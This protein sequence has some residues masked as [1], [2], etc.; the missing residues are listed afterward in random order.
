MTVRDHAGV[1]VTV[2]TGFLG[3]GKTTLVSALLRRAEAGRIAVIVNEVG[4]VGIDDLL[5]EPVAEDVALVSGGCLCCSARGDLVAALERLLAGRAAAALPPFD[6]ILIE[7]TGLAEPAPI[8]HLLTGGAGP[9]HGAHL[10]GTVTVVDALE[11]LGQLRAHPESV[12]QVALAERLVVGKVDLVDP[13]HVDT[14]EGRLRE[15]NPWAP[16]ARSVMGSVPTAHVLGSPSAGPMAEAGGRPLAAAPLAPGSGAGHHS[17]APR[18]FSLQRE[19]PFSRALLGMWLSRVLGELGGR[20]L[21]VKGLVQVPGAGG[22]LLVNAVQHRLYPLARL[23]AWPSADHRSRLVF[24]VEGDLQSRVLDVLE[25]VE[26]GTPDGQAVR[27]A[28][29]HVA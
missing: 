2:L 9:L 20:V 22:P 11:G 3:S 7:T 1:P 18:V 25:Q 14:L 19:R 27:A 28:E 16:I 26:R 17:R 13:G 29:E 21:R 4:D 23:P 12:H 15:L 5:I 6:R 10:A 8:L 24:V